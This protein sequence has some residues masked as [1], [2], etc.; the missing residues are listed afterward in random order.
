MM[1]KLLGTEE[2]SDAVDKVFIKSHLLDLILLL[3]P[4]STEQ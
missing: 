1:L 4:H 2:S 3:S